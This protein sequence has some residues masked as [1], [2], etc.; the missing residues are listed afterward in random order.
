VQEVPAVAAVPV[1]APH[2]VQKAK[3]KVSAVDGEYFNYSLYCGQLK[4]TSGQGS[5]LVNAGDIAAMCAV[6]AQA[7]EM[8]GVQ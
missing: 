3:L 7:A 4:M 2:P 1:A 6:I 5:V 8:M